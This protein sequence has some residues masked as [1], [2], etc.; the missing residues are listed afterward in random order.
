MAAKQPSVGEK[1]IA[2]AAL[3]FSLIVAAVVW[4]PLHQ[5]SQSQ[6]AVFRNDT[7]HD[8]RLRLCTDDTCTRFEIT[9]AWPPGSS[10]R[11]AVSDHGVLTRWL[12]VNAKT[13]ERLGCLPLALEHQ[14]ESVL[15]RAS[16]MRACSGTALVQPQLGRRLGV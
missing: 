15:V 4:N 9:D 2:G 3:V 8:A 16:Q 1:R 12:V 13:G 14:Y 11:E 6:Q 7:A 5:R 10:L